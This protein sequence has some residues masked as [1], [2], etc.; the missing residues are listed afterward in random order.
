MGIGGGSK[1]TLEKTWRASGVGTTTFNSP[2]NFSV[3][4]GKNKITVTGRGGAGAVG[5]ITSYNPPT[6]P[7]APYNSPTYP[8]ATYN[9]PAY[10]VAT[11]NPPTYPGATYNPPNYSVAGYNPPTYPVASYTAVPGNAASYNPPA[12]VYFYSGKIGGT[13]GGYSYEF[14]D[15]TYGYGCPAPYYYSF[16]LPTYGPIVGYAY[17]FYCWYI[18]VEPGGVASYNPPTNAAATYNTVPGNIAA[19]NTTPGNAITYN[20]AP[21]NAATYNTIPG[22]I[23]SYNTVPGNATTYNTVPGNASAYAPVYQYGVYWSFVPTYQPP[24]T[25]Y[26]DGQ[27]YD[28]PAPYSYTGSMAY[29]GPY[30]DTVNYSGCF[31]VGEGAIA[32]NPPTYAA[33][34]YSVSP[35]N[36]ATYNTPTTGP[37]SS[38]LGVTMPGGF[39][40][41]ASAI[42]PTSV[43]YYAIPDNSTQPVTVATGGYVT[44]TSE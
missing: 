7:Y 20:L 29:Y 8:A 34:Q 11:Y 40:G 2:G 36:A 19:Y 14:D 17:Y 23:A 42:S 13:F 24:V 31:Y 12:D 30:T 15:T 37:A 44:I 16:F 4:Y 3:P 10:P 27:G 22:N 25:L 28:C 18:G 43:S 33:I 32:Y 38:A 41:V 21:G 26:Y 1:F 6:Y 35:G 5:N 9:P 39:G